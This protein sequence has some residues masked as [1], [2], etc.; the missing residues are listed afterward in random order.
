MFLIAQITKFF[1]QKI[2]FQLPE[3]PKNTSRPNSR[4]NS[5]WQ[6]SAYLMGIC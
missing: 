3:V 6:D 4:I 1:T 5:H 2:T